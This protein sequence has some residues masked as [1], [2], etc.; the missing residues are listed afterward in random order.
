MSHAHPINQN[1]YIL[2]IKLDDQLEFQWAAMIGGPQN[3]DFAR[4]L[5]VTEEGGSVILGHSFSEGQ[6]AD[7]IV[8]AKLTSRGS[9]DWIRILGG[10][11]REYSKRIISLR[12]GGYLVCG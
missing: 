4:S 6:G 8:V 9:Q 11:G 3:Q 7:D 10:S 12:K 1:K 5:V 2:A